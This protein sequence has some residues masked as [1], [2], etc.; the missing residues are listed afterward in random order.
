MENFQKLSTSCLQPTTLSKYFLFT[1]KLLD[2]TEPTKW[3]PHAYY[4]VTKEFSVTMS[5]DK[6]RHF[7]S[8]YLLPAVRKDIKENKKLN[9]HYYSALR[10][11]LFKPASWFRGILFPF[12]EDQDVTI[13]EAEIIASIVIKVLFSNTL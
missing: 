5:A 4:E 7:L 10:R 9:Y 8:S 6:F 1:E 11:G 3:T 13:K 2:I 12:C